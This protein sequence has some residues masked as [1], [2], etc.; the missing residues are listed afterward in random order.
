MYDFNRFIKLKTDVS[1][2]AFKAQIKYRNNRNKFYLITFYFHKLL[3]AELN[4]FI[5][6]KEFLIIVNAFKEFRYYL[7]ETCT[8]LRFIL[9]IKTYYIF[10]SLKTLIND[11]YVTLNILQNSIT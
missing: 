5:Y 4:Y 7:K 6:D 11:N 1:D 2:Y 9:T 3:K 10:P 8:R